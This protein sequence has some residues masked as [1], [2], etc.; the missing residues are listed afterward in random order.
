[1]DKKLVPKAREA[2]IVGGNGGGDAG[3]QEILGRG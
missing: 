2:G 3:A 1:M